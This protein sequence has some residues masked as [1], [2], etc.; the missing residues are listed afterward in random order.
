MRSLIPGAPAP[1]Y[2]PPSSRRP[3]SQH[4]EQERRKTTLQLQTMLYPWWKTGSLDVG[5]GDGAGSAG[6]YHE[7]TR[8]RGKVGLPVDPGAHD[9]LVGDRTMKL[10]STQVKCKPAVKPLERPLSVQGVGNGS[11]QAD[12]SHGVEFSLHTDMRTVGAQMC[13][14]SAHRC[15]SGRTRCVHLSQIALRQTD[16]GGLVVLEANARSMVWSLRFVQELAERLHVYDLAWCWHE[17]R[18]D[19]R[20]QPCDT[21]IRI[22][23]NVDLPGPY[24]CECPSGTLRIHSKQLSQSE[25]HGRNEQVL[26]SIVQVALFCGSRMKQVCNLFPTARTGDPSQE[27]RALPQRKTLPNRSHQTRLK[28]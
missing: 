10:L 24:S 3:D 13:V 16:K 26:R 11:Q 27:I 1:K 23:T 15:V 25:R 4:G 2:P 8:V 12:L 7:R 21:V 18:M 20:A 6:V 17:R 9:N 5:S 19:V 22:A 14:L 28:P